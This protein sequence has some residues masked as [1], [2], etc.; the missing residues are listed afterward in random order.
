MRPHKVPK[1]VL[2]PRAA[3]PAEQKNREVSPSGK[4]LQLFHLLLAEPERIPARFPE[5][6]DACRHTEVPSQQH[7][8]QALIADGQPINE[9][10]FPPFVE[11]R[12]QVY[13]TYASDTPPELAI[14]GRSSKTGGIDYGNVPVYNDHTLTGIYPNASLNEAEKYTASIPHPGIIHAEEGYGEGMVIALYTDWMDGTWYH[15]DDASQLAT[16]DAD[17]CYEIE[18][19]LNFEGK[20]WNGS[21]TIFTGLFHGNGH[22]LSGIESKQNDQTT[23]CSGGVFGTIDASAEVTNVKFAGVSFHLAQVCT[24]AGCTYGLFAGAIEPEAKVE[25]VTVDGTLYLGV[26][27]NLYEERGD[28]SFMTVSLV[29]GNGENK[30]I[31]YAASK[32]EVERV[33]VGYEDITYA[34]VWGWFVRATVGEEGV[35]EI[36]LNPDKTQD[37]NP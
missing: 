11:E 24:R 1:Q 29:A 14:P 13:G 5:Q 21:R 15:I 36:S 30:D 34:E 23:T 9:E 12:W 2:F 35:V 20:T 16:L 28:Y 32:V 3:L 8:E 10:D 18:A 25:G 27:T 33:V 17:G 4:A 19:D 31:S 7:I 22:T 37:P 26:L 6:L